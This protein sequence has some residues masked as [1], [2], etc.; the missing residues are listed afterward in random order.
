MATMPRGRVSA[1]ESQQFMITLLGFELLFGIIIITVS[2]LIEIFFMFAFPL[3]A[4][5]KMS[6]LDA[7]KLSI[8]AGRANLGGVVGLMLLNGL[9]TI[10]GMLACIVGVYFYIPIAIASQAAAYRR[11][12]PDIGQVG[13]YPPPPPPQS[14]AA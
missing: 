11:V 5:R 3:V 9:F 6:G 13:Q 4:D 7:V 2:L 8:K 12:F 14:W 10:L 1:D